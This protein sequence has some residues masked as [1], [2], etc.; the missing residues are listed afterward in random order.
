MVQRHRPLDFGPR[1]LPV[2]GAVLGHPQ[3]QMRVAEVGVVRDRLPGEL[4]G[5]GG[6]SPL[7]IG[8]VPQAPGQVALERGIVGDP[9][10][11]LADRGDV[12]VQFPLGSQTSE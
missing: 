6:I 5:L 1:L 11:S 9:L 7:G 3:R 2:P 8:R 4:E 10:E 12:L